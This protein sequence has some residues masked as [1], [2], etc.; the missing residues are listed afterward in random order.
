MFE[1]MMMNVVDGL[2]YRACVNII[3]L[4]DLQKNCFLQHIM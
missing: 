3:P 1:R 4:C 2:D